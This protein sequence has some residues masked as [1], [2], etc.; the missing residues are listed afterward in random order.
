MKREYQIRTQQSTELKKF[1]KLKN[2]DGR[3][4]IHILWAK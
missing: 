3:N 1:F 4:I 2:I